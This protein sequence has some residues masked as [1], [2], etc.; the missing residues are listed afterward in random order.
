VVRVGVGLGRDPVREWVPVE[1]RDGVCERD[2]EVV[3]VTPGVHVSVR[4]S[5]MVQVIVGDRLAVGGER[6]TLAAREAECVSVPVRLANM[7]RLS[8]AVG[9][10]VRVNVGV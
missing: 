6:E 2:A 4:V 9:V 1:V 8:E 3:T 10:V 5:E 7:D